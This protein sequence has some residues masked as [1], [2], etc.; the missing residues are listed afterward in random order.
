MIDVCIKYDPASY[1]DLSLA[2]LFHYENNNW[3]DVTTSNDTINYIVCG[4]TSS[5]SPFAVFK[6]ID[7]IALL[8]ELAIR[9]RGYG[10]PSGITTSLTSKLQ[11]AVNALRAAK[12]N[13]STSACNI[14]DAFIN[15]VTAQSDKALT[16]NQASE[17]IPNARTVQSMVGCR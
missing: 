13:S 5:L 14:I 12:T 4:K 10:L 6:R 3:V 1:V 9:I 16:L 7:P 17:L 8:N 2:R 15:E 11:N